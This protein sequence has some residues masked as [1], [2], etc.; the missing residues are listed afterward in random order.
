MIRLNFMAPAIPRY[1]NIQNYILNGIASGEFPNGSQIPTELELSEQFKVSRMTV[2]KAITELSLQKVLT[3]IAGKGTFV[4]Q[5][6]AQSSSM[7]VVDIAVE[8][9]NRGNIHSTKLLEKGMIPANESVALALGIYVGTS[10][11][12]CHLI[13][14]ENGM[15]IL[16]EQR[17]VNATLVPNFYAQ[18]FTLMTPSGFLLANYALSEMEHTVDA[19]AATDSIAQHLQLALGDPCLYIS[20]RTWCEKELISFAHF[21]AAGSRYKLYSR[22]NN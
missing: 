16:L 18:D 5:Q 13:H 22:I 20:R 15:P 12:F 4:A 19:I 10:V 2:N 3:R 14:Y 7:H 6:K 21:T 9:K 8:I 11:A 17:Y 1:K